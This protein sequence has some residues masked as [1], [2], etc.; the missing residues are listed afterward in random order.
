MQNRDVY[1]PGQDV[2]A[3]DQHRKHEAFGLATTTRTRT[4]TKEA[5]SFRVVKKILNKSLVCFLICLTATDKMINVKY[6]MALYSSG[7]L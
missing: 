1:K 3:V 2:C 6:H 4:T 5:F 7:A